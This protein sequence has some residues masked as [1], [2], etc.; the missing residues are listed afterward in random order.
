MEQGS[1]VVNTEGARD[2]AFFIMEYMTSAEKRKRRRTL[3][4]RQLRTFCVA[5]D[6]G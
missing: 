1:V 2:V 4:R 5:V 6:L 3:A